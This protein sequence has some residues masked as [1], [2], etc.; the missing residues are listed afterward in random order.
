MIG[1]AFIRYSEE[2]AYIH[3]KDRITNLFLPFQSSF[4]SLEEYLG[5]EYTSK[6]KA[7]SISTAQDNKGKVY[8]LA[9]PETLDL[10]DDE[11]YVLLYFQSTGSKGVTSLVGMS[12]PFRVEHKVPSSASSEVD[13]MD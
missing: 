6:S 9:V 1:L 13:K 10:P 4:N 8:Q 3:D 2:L 11:E 5:Y 7:I 12:A